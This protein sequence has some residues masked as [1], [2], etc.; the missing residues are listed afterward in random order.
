MLSFLFSP[1]LT[2]KPVQTMWDRLL[3]SSLPYVLSSTIFSFSSCTIISFP[4]TF[5]FFSEKN[6][7]VVIKL[8]HVIYR[9]YLVVYS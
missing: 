2:T 4:V 5:L 6:F 7:T 8:S 3:N 1:I 9:G